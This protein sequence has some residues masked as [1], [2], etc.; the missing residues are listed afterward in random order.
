MIKDIQ[1]LIKK[2]GFEYEEISFINPV[3][4]SKITI[5]PVPYGTENCKGVE[6]NAN[7]LE[8]LEH[9]IKTF[10]KKEIHCIMFKVR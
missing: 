3:S 6:Y 1:N 7:T 8:E 2:Y 4:N 5:L 9:I 10:D